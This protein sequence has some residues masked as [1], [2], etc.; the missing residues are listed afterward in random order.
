MISYWIMLETK[1]LANAH[2]E[3]ICSKEDFTTVAKTRSLLEDKTAKTASYNNHERVQMKNWKPWK[4]ESESTV[5]RSSL[6]S[7]PP[8]CLPQSR[9]L[10]DIQFYL[11]RTSAHYCQPKL[12]PRMKT[13]PIRDNPTVPLAFYFPKTIYPVYFTVHFNESQ[14]IYIYLYSHLVS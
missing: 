12:G 3:L 14:H 4:W 9:F 7:W 10:L 2:L 8:S 1:L 11:C 13:S 5:D 6:T